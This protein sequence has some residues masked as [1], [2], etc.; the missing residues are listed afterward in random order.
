MDMDQVIL[1]LV[2]IKSTGVA[3]SATCREQSHAAAKADPLD[4]A[5]LSAAG[6]GATAWADQGK[7]WY[8][9]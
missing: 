5:S 1:A 4:S 7:L 2:T 6:E 9:G 8:I 3:A